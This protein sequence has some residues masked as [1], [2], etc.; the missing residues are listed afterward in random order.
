MAAMQ[1]L[2]ASTLKGLVTNLL[3]NLEQ[4]HVEIKD[5][6][7]FLLPWLPFVYQISELGYYFLCVLPWYSLVCQQ[8]SEPSPQPFC[9]SF[10]QVG[11]PC[12]SLYARFWIFLAHRCRNLTWINS[13]ML[14]DLV[15]QESLNLGRSLQSRG[16][17][18][19]TR[20]NEL[21]IW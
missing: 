1:Q 14:Y 6:F 2:V 20:S 15:I 5:G 12:N 19:P 3:I 16:R 10:S 17:F 7:L 8:G 4:K 18:M 21:G 13:R 11:H 9:L